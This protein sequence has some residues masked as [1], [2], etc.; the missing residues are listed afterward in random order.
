MKKKITVLLLLFIVIIAIINYRTPF[1]RN[2]GGPWSIGFSN[3]DKFPSQI[4]INKNRI[5]SNNKLKKYVANTEFMADPFFWKEKDTFYV[6][7]EHKKI[8]NYH[9]EIGLLTSTDGYNYQYKGTVLK[10]AFHLSY[11]QIFKYKKEFYMLPETQGSNNVLLYKSSKFPFDWK[12]CDTLIPNI[13]LK[14]PTI[15]LSDS[16]NIIVGTNDNYEM[17]LYQS[18]SLKDKWKLH[19]NKLVL[20]GT[21]SRPGGRIFADKNG[22]LLPVQN[23]SKG[24]GSGLSLYRLK[25]KNNNYTIKKEKHLLLNAQTDIK[26]FNAGMHHLD[27]QKIDDK[28]YCVYDGNTK[29]NET[30]VFNYKA[31]LKLTYLDTKNWL[32]QITRN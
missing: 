17:Q 25:F 18:N 3:F 31:P 20:A 21:E 27:I 2:T 19:Q 8:K 26:E 24:Y 23:N 5:Y 22:L 4:S 15:Y 14:D 10:E 11:P 32:H 12:V 29:K 7:F 9:A 16:L 6:F 28:Y 1:F 30:K 13:R